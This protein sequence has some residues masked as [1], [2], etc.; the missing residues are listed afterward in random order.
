MQ[1]ETSLKASN[2]QAAE[3]IAWLDDIIEDTL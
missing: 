1:A 2:A 3:T